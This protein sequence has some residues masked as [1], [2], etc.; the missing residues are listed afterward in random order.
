[1]PREYHQRNPRDFDKIK[2]S[3]ERLQKDR[4]KEKRGYNPKE[5]GVCEDPVNC[6]FP[7]CM[8]YE[9]AEKDVPT[10]PKNK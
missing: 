6:P 8:C 7:Y 5:D 3:I 2:R 1:M 10:K 4:A 9:D